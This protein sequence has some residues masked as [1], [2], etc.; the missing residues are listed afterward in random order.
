MIWYVIYFSGAL[1]TFC[2][3]SYFDEE[4]IR[5][6]PQ[7]LL[8]SL[9]WVIIVPLWI[10]IVSVINLNAGLVSLGKKHRERKAEKL[11]LRIAE[12]K[13]A[14]LALQEAEFEVDQFVEGLR[15][16]GG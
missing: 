7:L 8:V 10:M 14:D 9:M 3:S 15:N 5:N 2:A 13:K 4:T 6:P 16:Q 1:I 12:E 11:K